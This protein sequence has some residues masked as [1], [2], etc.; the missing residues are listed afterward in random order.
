[1]TTLR[2]LHEELNITQ[3]LSLYVKNQ[4]KK[5]KPSEAFTADGELSKTMETLIRINTLG[6]LGR[7]MEQARVM[8][9]AASVEEGKKMKL[10]QAISD[11]T[12]L[13][14]Q[15]TEAKRKAERAEKIV[16]NANMRDYIIELYRASSL[17][18]ELAPTTK[19]LPEDVDK[20]AKKYTGSAFDYLNYYTIAEILEKEAKKL[21][22][23]LKQKEGK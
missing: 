1:M 12:S 20:M 8:S 5:Y 10:A 4:N 23:Y 21:I 9:K 7:H 15:L 16:N 17:A 19:S 14:I 2:K 6:K 13:K 3:R 22:T 18:R 11:N